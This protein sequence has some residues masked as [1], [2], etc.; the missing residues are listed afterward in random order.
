MLILTLEK[1]V[2]FKVK[3]KGNL[4][5]EFVGLLINM[6]LFTVCDGSE[7]SLGSNYLM[8]I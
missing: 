4:I 6:Y 2:F 5:V 7:L 1:L 8:D 3:T